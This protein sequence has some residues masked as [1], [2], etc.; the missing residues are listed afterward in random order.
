MTIYIHERKR[1]FRFVSSSLGKI[2][3]IRAVQSCMSYIVSFDNEFTVI[4]CTCHVFNLNNWLQ[5][6]NMSF[7][8]YIPSTRNK[9]HNYL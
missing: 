4:T 6:G 1:L 3:H 2:K 9:K 5:R 8:I 7:H